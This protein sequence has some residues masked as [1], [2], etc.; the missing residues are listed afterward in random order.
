MSDHLAEPAYSATP[1][2][3]KVQRDAAT[4]FTTGGALYHRVRPGYVSGVASWLVGNGNAQADVLDLGAGTG[5]LT[6][7]LIDLAGTVY[8]VDPSEDMLGQLAASLPRVH[9]L[10]GTAEDLPLPDESVDVVCVAQAWHWFHSA[11]ASAQVARVL[12]PGGRLGLIWNQLDV[13]QPWVMRL[14]RIMHSGDVHRPGFVPE[15][16][17]QFTPLASRTDQWQQELSTDELF[18]LVKSRSY[19]LRANQSTRERVM[20]NL[21]WYLFENLG[22]KPTYPVELP[23]VSNAWVYEK[24]LF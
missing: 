5:K 4:A 14:S 19:Y 2:R 15:V 13:S 22:H 20:Q 12:R 18:D 1:L 11:A 8:A 9:T 6:Q 16:G 21:R 23:Y 24:S 3:P 17:E 10:L 7:D